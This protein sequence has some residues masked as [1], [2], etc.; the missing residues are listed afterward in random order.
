M[1]GFTFVYP[2][3][4]ILAQINLIGEPVIRRV[5]LDDYKRTFPDKKEDYR[6]SMKVLLQEQMNA[7]DE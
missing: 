2:P 4:V 1:D 7:L 5:L 3:E 6:E